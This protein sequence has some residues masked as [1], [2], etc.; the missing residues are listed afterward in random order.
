MIP[1]ETVSLVLD[2]TKANVRAIW[3]KHGFQPTTDVERALMQQK[4]P[5]VEQCRCKFCQKDAA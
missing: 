4:N 5:H 2:T 3:E 1:E